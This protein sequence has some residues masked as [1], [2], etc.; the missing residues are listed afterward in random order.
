[1]LSRKRRTNPS[2]PLRVFMDQW[3]ADPAAEWAKLI[4]GAMWK[5]DSHTS[6]G[7]T[8]IVLKEPERPFGVRDPSQI[9]TASIM[10]SKDVWD[11]DQENDENQEPVGMVCDDEDEEDL[12][13]DL[14]DDIFDAIDEAAIVNEAVKAP[15]PS[16]RSSTNQQYN[17]QSYSVSNTKAQQFQR[18]L[19]W[20]NLQRR[21]NQNK[22]NRANQR[23]RRWISA[24]RSIR[25]N[26]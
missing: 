13:G 26:H 7:Q 17:V 6:F 25:I 2:F 14:D 22:A 12:W 15:A 10:K 11:G 24:W 18:I 20:S 4:S 8:M 1:M 16:L 23:R 9:A 3:C 19:M 21:R 5:S